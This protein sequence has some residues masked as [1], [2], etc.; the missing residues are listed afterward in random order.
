[1]GDLGL[2]IDLC[3]INTAILTLELECR[4]KPRILA[5]APLKRYHLS[6]H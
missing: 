6:A 3:L 1:M 5:D 4:E 2:D